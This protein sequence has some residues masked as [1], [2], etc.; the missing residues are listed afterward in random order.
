MSSDSSVCAWVAVQIDL[1]HSLRVVT[2][3]VIFLV[4]NSSLLLKVKLKHTVVCNVN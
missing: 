4:N 3:T 2:R 1:L